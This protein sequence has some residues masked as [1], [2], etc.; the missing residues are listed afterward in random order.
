MWY[1]ADAA[2]FRASTTAGAAPTAAPSRRAKRTP[3]TT[4]K[5]EHTRRRNCIFPWAGAAA[6]DDG[7]Y[8]TREREEDV[9]VGGCVHDK[10]YL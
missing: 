4:A 6:I 7:V 1:S 5:F 2:P 3:G 9:C 8:E 10:A